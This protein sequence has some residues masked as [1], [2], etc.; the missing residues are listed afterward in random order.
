MFEELNAIKTTLELSE[1]HVDQLI[2]A[3][4]SLLKNNEEYIRFLNAI[5]EPRRH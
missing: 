4:R 3:G 1:E 5:N 2:T